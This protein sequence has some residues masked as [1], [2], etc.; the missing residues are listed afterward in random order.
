MTTQSH[1]DRI[2]VRLLPARGHYDNAIHRDRNLLRQVNE[3]YYGKMAKTAPESKQLQTMEQLHIFN[4][5]PRANRYLR[6]RSPK[7]A[8][9][10]YF[11][12]A[13]RKLYS[14]NI[15][16]TKYIAQLGTPKLNMLLWFV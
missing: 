16:F 4:E 11:I 10:C 6:D 5:L 13:C 12:S 1:H 15:P 8:Y 7:L 2:S 14:R 9:R 3:H